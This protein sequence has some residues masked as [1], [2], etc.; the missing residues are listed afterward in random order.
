MNKIQAGVTALYSYD[1]EPENMS[2]EN[3]L[4]QSIQ[5]ISRLPIIAAHA[6]SVKRHVFDQDSLL[7]H[8]PQPGPCLCAELHAY[9][10]QRCLV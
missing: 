5:L 7:L 2:L 8:R 3:Q 1:P 4:K 10:G 6:Y 9:F